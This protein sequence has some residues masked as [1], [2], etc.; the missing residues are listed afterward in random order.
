[1]DK[2]DVIH[3][4]IN[5]YNG[6]LFSHEKEGSLAI[7][8]IWM[9]LEDVILNEVSGRERQLLCDITS[10]RSPEKLNSR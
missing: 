7:S 8:A 6:I 10:I 2:E 1:M 9:N 3:I 4:H 5:T